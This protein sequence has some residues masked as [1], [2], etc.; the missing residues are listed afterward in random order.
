MS[1]F[2]V[3]ASELNRLSDLDLIA[4]LQNSDNPEVLRKRAMGFV[5][6]NFQGFIIQKTKGY[7][8]KG[9]DNDELLCQARVGFCKGIEKFDLD[10]GTAITT[11]SLWWILK[12]IKQAFKDATPYQMSDAARRELKIIS[13]IAA[14]LDSWDVQG[15]SDASGFSPKKIERLLQFRSAVPLPMHG[16]DSSELRLAGDSDIEAEVAHIQLNEAL[17]NFISGLTERDQLIFRMKLIEEQSFNTI[18]QIIGTSRE[19][20]R[21]IFLALQKKA[22][23]ALGYIKG[24]FF[25]VPDE[26]D[27]QNDTESAPIETVESVEAF[28]VVPVG[29][30]PKEPRLFRF[31]LEGRKFGFSRLQSL[32]SNAMNRIVSNLEGFG[33]QE[34]QLQPTECQSPQHDAP[35]FEEMLNSDRSELN[36]NTPELRLESMSEDW[37]RACTKPRK[38][39]CRQ[40][41]REGLAELLESPSETMQKNLNSLVG[42]KVD[43]R[44]N[45]ADQG[46]DWDVWVR[47]TSDDTN[48]RE[49]P[50]TWLNGCVVANTNQKSILPD[51]FDSSEH[52]KS[53]DSSA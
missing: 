53:L 18:G 19:S 17:A 15:L 8:N 12:Y 41:L 52:R 51:E 42:R 24:L 11:Y 2:S 22:Q 1:L 44:I 50:L 36:R 37:E 28:E 13:D 34:S 9:V 21:R 4:Y 5:L 16:E 31:V 30:V 27:L 35:S 25:D 10:K 23:E 7:F 48:N 39:E 38:N 29:E 14:K 47:E 43:G 26:I 20:V 6:D 45:Q 46:I 33:F 32:F 49:R 3:Q 40:A